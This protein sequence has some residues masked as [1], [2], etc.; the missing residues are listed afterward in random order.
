MICPLTNEACRGFPGCGLGRPCAAY[1][2]KLGVI[3]GDGAIR[4]RAGNLAAAIHETIMDHVGD[5]LPT[6]VAVGVLEI[7]KNQILLKQAG[8][9]EG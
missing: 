6:A 8:L 9:D 5:E 7:V 3:E 4:E 1:S 2:N